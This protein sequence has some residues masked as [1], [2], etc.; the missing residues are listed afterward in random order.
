MK[1]NEKRAHDIAITLFVEAAKGKE[2]EMVNVAMEQNKSH[3]SVTVDYYA[4][5]K[6]IYDS[7]LN[8]LNRDYPESEY[9]KENF[10][11]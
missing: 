9:N 8:A 6:S 3:V 10:N 4:I 11:V 1:F 7:V 2:Q 5:Y